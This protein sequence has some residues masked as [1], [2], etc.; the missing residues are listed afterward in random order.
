MGY[1]PAYEIYEMLYPKQNKNRRPR[2]PKQQLTVID[3][4]KRAKLAPFGASKQQAAHYQELRDIRNQ[5]FVLEQ[6]LAKLR[7]KVVR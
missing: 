5:I 4:E 3:G 6:R 2:P 7:A 1:V